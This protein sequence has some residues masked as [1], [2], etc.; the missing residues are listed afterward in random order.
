MTGH[1]NNSNQK[2]CSTAFIRPGITTIVA[3]T[4]EK[5]VDA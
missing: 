4:E 1:K 5:K 2:D 3:R